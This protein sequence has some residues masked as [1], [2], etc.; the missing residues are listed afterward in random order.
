MPFR[1]V[2][3]T[4]PDPQGT[5]RVDL[6]T[7]PYT[8]KAYAAGELTRTADR[9]SSRDRYSGN[10]RTRQLAVDCEGSWVESTHDAYENT[11]KCGELKLYFLFFPSAGELKKKKS[12]Q[13]KRRSSPSTVYSMRPNYVPDIRYPITENSIFRCRSCLC[14]PAVSVICER[15][16]PFP[17]PCTSLE[18]AYGSRQPWR[19]DKYFPA[20]D[21]RYTI[22]DIRYIYIV[23]Y[24]RLAHIAGWGE[25]ASPV[26]ARKNYQIEHN[27]THS[28]ARSV[29]FGMY[30][31]LVWRCC[32]GCGC[33][34]VDEVSWSDCRETFISSVTMWRCIR[35]VCPPIRPLPLNPLAQR[36]AVETEVE[37]QYTELTPIPRY[38]ST[39]EK[40]HTLRIIGR[41]F[42]WV[43]RGLVVVVALKTLPAN[44]NTS[45]RWKKRAAGV[46]RSFQRWVSALKF[47]EL[48]VDVSIMSL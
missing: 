15:R 6:F 12:S 48:T 44:N 16:V 2:I 43:W 36:G 23:R 27:Q 4:A 14:W 24:G 11:R 21:I 5:G 46:S 42:F 29:F 30:G 19:G 26:V 37:L 34:V 40:N 39:T 20:S 38:A 13:V 41:F 1:V 28:S 18:R 10:R 31:L 45:I 22:S 9:D 3:S 8:A 17:P 33:I 47:T 7:H 35:A 32:W 25:V